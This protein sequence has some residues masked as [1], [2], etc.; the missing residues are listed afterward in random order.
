MGCV[1]CLRYPPSEMKLQI[2]K[3]VIRDFP[4]LHTGNN[5]L[6]GCVSN[7]VFLS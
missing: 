1:C 4:A 5:L 2:A 3:S 6:D 7:D